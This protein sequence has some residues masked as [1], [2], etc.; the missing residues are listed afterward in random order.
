M[1]APRTW[2]RCFGLTERAVPPTRRAEAMAVAT[3]AIVGGQALAVAVTGRLAESYG[4]AAAFAAASTAAALAC[5]IAL[6]AGPSSYTGP[7]TEAGRHAR[8]P[9]RQPIT[10][11][12]EQGWS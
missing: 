2:S 9:D 4:P 7:T 5:A 11:A 1:P 3:S 12:R 6:T 8:V 10:P